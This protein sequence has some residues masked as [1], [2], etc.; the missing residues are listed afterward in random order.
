MSTA[1]AELPDVD[2]RA[3]DLD[4]DA[5]G[6]DVAALTAELL[7]TGPPPRKLLLRGARRLVPRLERWA[8]RPLS[9]VRLQP[10][11]TGTLDNVEWRS[12]TAPA[13]VA[14]EVRLRVLASG[15]N[16]RDVLLALGMYPN[17]TSIALGAECAGVVEIVGADVVG[18][19][20]GDVVFGFAPVALATEVTVP[21]A[22]LSRVPHSL[23]PEQAAALP[24]A[25]L[26]GMYGLLRVARL[27][28]G[29]SVLIHAAAGGVGLAAVQ[30]ALRAGA[31]VFATAGSPAKRE[32]LRE[33]GVPHIFDSRSL[34][35][36]TAIR[37]LTGGAGVDVVLNSLAGDFIPASFSVLARGGCSWSWESGTS[38]RRSRHSAS[39][40][41]RT[42]LLMIWAGRF[43]PI[44]G[45]ALH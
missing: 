20:A 38:G 30:L 12:A 44:T 23:S 4:A 29:Q 3:I 36:A 5:S 9:Q 27:R 40:P 13:P 8:E 41:T 22:F 32:L 10:G 7:R 35:F 16:F 39:D 19:K 43:W 26:T 2:C 6:G 33:M 31:T 21:A 25:Y 34:G 17:G 15:I 1:A 11:G 18:M 28:A 42:M 14:G 37:D 45:S 24:V